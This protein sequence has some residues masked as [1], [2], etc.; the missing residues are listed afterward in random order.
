MLAPR[1]LQTAFRR[2]LLE[3]DEAALKT[4]LPEIADGDLTADQRLAVYRNNVFASLSDALKETFPAVCRLVDERFFAYAAHE[5]IAAHPP[6]RPALMEYGG[7]FPDF[8]A[9][10]P[11]CRHLAYLS[12]VA[13][14]EWLMNS[15]AHAS[16]A[17]PV[18][19]DELASFAPEDPAQLGFVLHPSYGYIESTYPIDIIWR[20][21]RPGACGEEVIDLAAGGACL[22]VSRQG[23]DVG[24]RKLDK[25]VF[26]FR[27]ALL[28]GAPLGQALAQ[29]LAFDSKFSSA[30]ALAALFDEGAIT[31]FSVSPVPQELAT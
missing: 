8:L 14:F 20:A 22:E 13:R 19:P 15:A 2:A 3:A 9:A 25:P 28:D 4:L 10:F 27:R 12:D 30:D 1:D 16:D 18:A 6:S 29:A 26:V 23:G 31:R 11:P 17:D 21:N 5:F 7:A 24:F